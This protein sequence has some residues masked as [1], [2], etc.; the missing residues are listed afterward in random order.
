MKFETKY[1]EL[2]EKLIIKRL[3]P[4]IWKGADIDERV[5]KGLLQI[6]NDFLDGL[7]VKINP[8][9]IVLTGSSANYNW[10]PQSD[11]DVHIVVDFKKIKSVDPKVLSDY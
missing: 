10:T 4:A 9:D 8:E 2:L 3:N 5:R 7:R 6:V 1:S 11:I